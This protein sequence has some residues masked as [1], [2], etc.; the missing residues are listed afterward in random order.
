MLAT[1]DHRNILTLTAVCGAA[2]PQSDPSQMSV[3]D[4]VQRRLSEVESE[5]RAIRGD[6]GGAGEGQELSCGS[7]F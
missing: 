7:A 2:G 1:L 5:R 6:D 4:L 3:T